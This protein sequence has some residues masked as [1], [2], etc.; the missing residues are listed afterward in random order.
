[1][2]WFTECLLI[3]A[4]MTTVII[5]SQLKEAK[6][7]LDYLKATRYAKILKDYIPNDETVIAINEV[8]DGK[9]NAY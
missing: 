9:V 1:M 6:K 3:T 2:T 4:V 7:K 8:E 5:D